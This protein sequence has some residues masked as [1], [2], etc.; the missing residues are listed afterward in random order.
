LAPLKKPGRFRLSN[1]LLAIAIV[2]T[3]AFDIHAILVRN[4]VRHTMK[5][6]FQ[7]TRPY[8]FPDAKG[9]PTGPSVEI[10]QAAAKRQ[11]IALQWIYSPQGPEKALASGAVDLWPIM[12]DLPERRNILYVS[13]P[14]TKM[15]Y[16]MVVPESLGV[17]QTRDLAGKTV[18]AVTKISS[19]GHVARQYFG[20]STLLPRNS[21]AEVL[22]AVCSGA[23]QAGLISLNPFASP[24]TLNCS[25]TEVSILP[26]DGAT[27]W[28]GVGANKHS[29]EAKAAAER[30]RDEIGRM[31]ADGRLAVVDFHWNAKISMETSTI[32]AYR[33]TR[34][35]SI[36]L[37]VALGILGPTLGVMFFLTRRLRV[38]QAQAEAATHAKSSFLAA[39]SHEVRTPMNAVIGMTGLLL[40][41]DLTSEQRDFAETVRRSGEALLGVINDILDFSKIEAG[42]LAIESFPFDLRLV[43]E[44]VN[45]MLAP[46]A[47]D[48][49]LDLVLE[50]APTVPRHFIGDAGRIRQVVTNLVGNAVKFTAS[51]YVLIHVECAG[52]ADGTA[53]I[54]VV[55]QDTGTGIPK[56]KI[57]T[58][59]KKFSQVDASTTRKYGGTGLGLA[60][61]KQ[62]VELMGGTVGVDS[63][64]EQGSTFWFTLPLKMDEQPLAA[65]APTD[66]LRG[67]RVMIV[68]DIEINRRVLHEQIMSWDMRNGSFASAEG[69]IEAL[70]KARDEG[71]P[72]HFVLLDY[73]MP[74]MDGATLAAAIKADAALSDTSIVMLTSIG[75]WSEVR[76]VAG[77]AIDA[78]LVK[79]VR[80]SQLLNT[81][82]TTWSKKLL[83]TPSPAPRPRL[84][85][86][87]LKAALAADLGG[88]QVRILVAEDNVV[89]QKVAVRMLEKL[90]LR[91]DVAANGRE[92]VDMCQLCPYDV[93]LMDCHMPEM[94][95]YTAT[96]EI[97]R[98]ETGRERIVI[99]A[100]TAE[101]MDGCR[102]N[103]LA[104]GMDDYIAKPA[105]IEDVAAALRK[106]VGTGSR[107]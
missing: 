62:L 48:K 89:N 13:A 43:M 55:V 61:T 22:Y 101:A 74:G 23:A 94:D 6:G 33:Q 86:D 17:A 66:D 60:I 41:T 26:I 92:A 49:S 30:L 76:N 21:I 100:M 2:A 65:P 95:G 4:T 80:Q 97:R 88:N 10:L 96:R 18:A 5:V 32:F 71:D 82:A 83:R 78:C 9:N 37:M 59:F 87:D 35:Y 46:R 25:G 45:E 44:E 42:K 104:A 11:H 3:G 15:T 67:L 98:R 57:D 20:K 50:Y 85:L 34:F 51:G 56:D 54:R 14:W 58:L 102:E 16:A 38:A 31:A 29:P 63:V 84:R 53:S 69:V 90:G 7:N 79:P 28:F 75:H 19:D 93:V 103:C 68:D 1:V 36:I 12:A 39:M 40:D 27:Y 91:A 81:L 72:Y 107:K 47:E 106:W 24:G 52:E 77:N 8:H 105:K 73:Q 99:I 64:P 70:Y